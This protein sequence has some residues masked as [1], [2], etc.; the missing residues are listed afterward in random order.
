MTFLK[1]ILTFNLPEREVDC[2]QCRGTGKCKSQRTTGLTQMFFVGITITWIFSGMN[3]VVGPNKF[4]ISLF[5]IST[6]LFVLIMYEY[7]KQRN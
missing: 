3:M 1:H 5:I 7:K 4:N 6:I 2:I